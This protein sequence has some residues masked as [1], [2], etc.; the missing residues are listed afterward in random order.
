MKQMMIPRILWSNAMVGCAAMLMAP[1]ILFRPEADVLQLTFDDVEF[2][3]E[4][5][6]EFDRDMLT[7]DINAMEGRRISIRGFILPNGTSGRPATR[8]SSWYATIRNAV[9]GR[10]RRFT[11]AFG[12]DEGRP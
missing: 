7:D 10:A 5:D 6:E 3:M 2:E 4:Q 1:G 11:I 8:N 9:L 12:E